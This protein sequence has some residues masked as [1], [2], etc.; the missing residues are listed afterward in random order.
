MKEG[1]F[2]FFSFFAIREKKDKYAFQVE[3]FSCYSYPLR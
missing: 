3:V 2:S 1:F